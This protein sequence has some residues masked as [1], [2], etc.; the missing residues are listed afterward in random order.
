LFVARTLT[1]LRSPDVLKMVYFSYFHSVMS[2]GIIFWGNSHHS[3]KIFKIKKQIV[4]IITNSNR[5]DTCHPLFKWLQILPLQSQ[6]ILSVLLFVIKNKNLFQLNSQVYN[7]HTRSNN[8]L[9]LLST[10]LHWFRKVLHILDE[11]FTTIYHHKLKKLRLMQ[12]RLKLRWRNSF[13]NMFFTVLMNII[14]KIIMIMLVSKLT[15]HII[16]KSIWIMN[17]K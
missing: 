1:F 7:I 5:Y 14:N 4:R 6:Y 15:S 3:V 8:N 9:H 11:K 16:E 12:P 2:Y 10:D 17:C 13:F